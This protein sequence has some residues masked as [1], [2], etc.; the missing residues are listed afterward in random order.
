MKYEDILNYRQRFKALTSY[1]V[2]KFDELLLYFENELEDYF[3]HYNFNGKPRKNKY[4]SKKPK[5]SYPLLAIN[6]SLFCIIKIKI[7]R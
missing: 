6:F 7:L 4:T 1:D 2:K 3:Q 5:T